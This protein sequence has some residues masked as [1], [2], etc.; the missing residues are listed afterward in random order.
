MREPPDGDLQGWFHRRLAGDARRGKGRPAGPRGSGRRPSGQ[1]Q[2]AGGPLRE[3]GG[4]RRCAAT[5]PDGHGR[6]PQELPAGG[7]LSHP[8]ALDSRGEMIEDV[9]EALR[10]LVRREAVPGG[11]IDVAFDAPTKDWSS[12]RNTPTV[13][14]YLYDIREDMPRR[15]VGRVDLP[16]AEGRT[17]AHR[18]PP[19][20]F[21][22]SYLLT[23]WTQRPE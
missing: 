2:E 19:R 8:R 3:P 7:L 16:N 11:D 4:A 14:L 21:K 13:D 18:L 1:P 6:M 9:D 23:A 22:L 17:V 12:R 5:C 20:F 15:D 10:T